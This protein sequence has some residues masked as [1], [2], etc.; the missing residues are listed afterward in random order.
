MRLKA[1]KGRKKRNKK[2]ITWGLTWLHLR[3]ACK[4][5]MPVWSYLSR[6]INLSCYLNK[7]FSRFFSKN[8]FS[9][10]SE[11]R[12]ESV[13]LYIDASWDIGFGGYFRGSSELWCVCE[14]DQ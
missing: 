13:E 9:Q 8:F 14:D 10:E 3:V 7:L 11:I 6:L 12:L 2:G 1:F 5:A 4:V